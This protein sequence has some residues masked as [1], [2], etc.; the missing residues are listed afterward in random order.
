MINLNSKDINEITGAQ[1]RAA[2]ALL[3]WS[4]RDLAAAASVGVA[5]VS[6]AE[7]HN[8]RPPLTIPILRALKGALEDA[9]IEFISEGL[10]GAGVCFR[11]PTDKR[12]RD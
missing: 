3:Q 2:R 9:G 12:V 5:T 1:I 11:L 7:V 4:A 8:E 6:R 10:R